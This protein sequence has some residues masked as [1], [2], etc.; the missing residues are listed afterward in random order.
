MQYSKACD[1]FLNFLHGRSLPTTKL[2][3]TI[4]LVSKLKPSP[5]KFYG[6][7]D[8][9]KSMSQMT[10]DAYFFFSL[11]PIILL[12]D[13]TIL[14]TQTLENFREKKKKVKNILSS[15]AYRYLTYIG[16]I[17][18]MKTLAVP[19]FVQNLTVLPNSPV[20]VMK[21]MQDICYKFL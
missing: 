14:V 19:I 12:P 16:W 17:T 3:N 15:W 21:E 20:Q 11:S 5:R 8:N 7:H 2:L 4:F 6:R 9:G 1:S 13:L 10:S 18:V